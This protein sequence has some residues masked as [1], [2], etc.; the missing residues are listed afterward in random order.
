MLAVGFCP[1]VGSYM[2]NWS[3]VRQRVV[4]KTPMSIQSIEQFTLPRIGLLGLG[5]GGCPRVSVWWSCPM[6]Y[7]AAE[8][9]YFNSFAQQ[10]NALTDCTTETHETQ[11]GGSRDA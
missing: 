7:E 3:W 11:A 1:L 2:A 8:M 5:Q 10:P 6:D 9:L 4:Q